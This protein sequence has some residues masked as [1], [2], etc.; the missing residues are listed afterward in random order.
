MSCLAYLVDCLTV[1]AMAM[2]NER[3]MH[4]LHWSVFNISVS[5][6]INISAAQ[7]PTTTISA[8]EDHHLATYRRSISAG[9]PLSPSTP[10]PLV[11]DSFHY[12]LAF[13]LIFHVPLTRQHLEQGFAHGHSTLQVQ[14]PSGSS[15]SVAV[16]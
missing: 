6:P 7:R 13:S 5:D 4:Q 14:S 9:L 2:M 15:K 16:S 11:F 8:V 3:Q 10:L 12:P 1:K